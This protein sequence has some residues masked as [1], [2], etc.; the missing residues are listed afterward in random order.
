MIKCQ[1]AEAAAIQSDH[2]A[3]FCFDKQ[4]AELAAGDEDYLEFQIVAICGGGDRVG[5]PD[6]SAV[7][8]EPEPGIMTWC[9]A[10]IRMARGSK[11]CQ[12]WR[13]PLDRLYPLEREFYF[14]FV[15]AM[16]R[17]GSIVKAD[18]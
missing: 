12:Q 6:N 11:A 5:T 2:V 8:T 1:E 16:Q 9:E 14:G 15:H 7:M 10:E 13:V 17:Q 4:L 3:N 18:V